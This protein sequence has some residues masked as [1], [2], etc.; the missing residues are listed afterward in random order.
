MKRLA[1]IALRV[2]ALGIPMIIAACYGMP[3]RFSRSGKVIDQESHDSIQDIKISCMDKSGTAT[4]YTNSGTEGSWYLYY[5][6]A[7]DH[8]DAEDTMNPAR[9]VKTTVAFPAADGSTISMQK[10]K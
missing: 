2:V 6:V 10:V 9:Y 8:L 3:A 4:D 7:C 1:S 5:D